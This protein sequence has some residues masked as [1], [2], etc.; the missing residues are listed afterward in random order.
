MERHV[1]VVFT[2]CVS[3]EDDAFN[4]WYNNTHLRD[5]LELEGFA[6]AQRFRLSQMDDPKQRGGH[7]YLALYEIEGNLGDALQRLSDAGPNRFMSPSF[8]TSKTRR[9]VYT[10]ITDRVTQVHFGSAT[11]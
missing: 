3:G 10:A 4:D 2:E 11:P 1:M 5:V 6:A 8:D 7:A 9:L